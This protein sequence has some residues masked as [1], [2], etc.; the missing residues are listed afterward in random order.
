MDFD[1]TEEQRAFCQSAR[2]FAQQALA[3]YAAQWDQQGH[4]PRQVLQQ[5]G[6]LGFCGL[7]LP[8]Q[9]GGMQASR[10][11][12]CLIF[13]ELAK[14]CPAT[15]AWLAIHNMAAALTAHAPGP[16]ARDLAPALASGAKLASFCLTE[17]GAGSDAAA[18]ATRARPDGAGWRLDGGKV[19]ISGAGISDVLV[20]F[21]RSDMQASGRRGIS[22][23]ALDAHAPGVSYGRA[24]DKLGWRAQPTRSIHF[25]GV[26][27]HA[28]QLL[29]AAGE[30]FG[31]AMRS[32]DGGRL[33]IAACSL[34]GAQ[35]ALQLAQQYVLQRR[36]FSRPLSEFQAL[37]FKLADMQTQLV[38]ARQMVRLAAVRLDAGRADASVYCAMAKRL[39]TDAGYAICNEALQIHG[40]NGLTAE[41]PLERLL[42]DLRTHQI[43]EGANEIMRVIIAR[44]ILQETTLEMD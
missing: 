34:G 28:G 5:A 36:Q 40:G 42:R 38:A 24:E 31:L 8:E 11:D 22:A 18:L 30:G 12:G 16:F 14:A 26:R 4:V 2:A 29:G 35:A 15:A 10:L 1:L 21:A 6:E 7:Y 17:A 44:H 23:F 27:L 43:V 20:V 13:E 32:L 25:D 33:N 9:L 41:Y 19:F 39:A 37:Q 3:P